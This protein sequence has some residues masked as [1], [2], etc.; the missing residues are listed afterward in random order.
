M[1]VSLLK[2]PLAVLRTTIG[3]G[4][5]EMAELVGRSVRTIQA[6]ELNTLPLSEDL[7]K[8]IA[9]KTGVSLKW[10][11][12]GNPDAPIVEHNGGPYTKEIFE[13]VASGAGAPELTTPLDGLLSI[14]S[15]AY[16]FSEIYRGSLAAMT[17]A[18][19]ELYHYKVRR[20]VESVTKEY[21]GYDDF[22][23]DDVLLRFLEFFPNEKTMSRTVP[24]LERLKK[25]IEALPK[26]TA[27]FV[28]AQRH[29]AARY[30]IEIGKLLGQAE[31][32]FR[33]RAV[34]RKNQ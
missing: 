3:L 10:L 20:A 28:A 7:G 5:K 32:N 24:V 17:K 33:K 18:D 14:V 23:E 11:M 30:F 16:V 4:Q 21:K 25:A 19:S 22:Q 13:R 15:V 1:R 26:T 27:P 9:V 6:V 12:D 34:K 2:H 8:T 31:G 29:M